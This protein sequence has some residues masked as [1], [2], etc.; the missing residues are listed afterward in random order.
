MMLV[1]MVIGILLSVAVPQWIHTREVTRNT[2]C[3]CNLAQI[4]RAKE[5]FGMD[6]KLQNGS[7]VSASDLWPEYIKGGSFPSCPSGGTYSVN[8]LGTPSSCSV[9]GNAPE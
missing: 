2:G 8:P 9:H 1:I 3:L 4:D 5:M 6:A 7:Q